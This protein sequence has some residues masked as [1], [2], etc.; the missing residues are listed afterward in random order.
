MTISFV[1]READDGAHAADQAR[2]E[3]AELLS[4]LHARDVAVASAEAARDDA[5]RQARSAQAG[6][7][8]S[9]C[10]MDATFFFEL[11][12]GGLPLLSGRCLG[13]GQVGASLEQ[14]LNMFRYRRAFLY[15]R[16]HALK[17][18]CLHEHHHG[19]STPPPMRYKGTPWLYHTAA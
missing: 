19:P 10:V 11:E 7:Q 13:G 9:A 6:Y 4:R 1:Q 12:H 2:A 8:D 18:F 3:G 17:A 5:L 14:C 15:S 16:V